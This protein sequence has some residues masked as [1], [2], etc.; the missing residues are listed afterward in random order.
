MYTY[1]PKL[2]RLHPLVRPQRATDEIRDRPERRFRRLALRRMARAGQQHDL[3]RAVAFL[4][5]DLD[6]L[7]R[8]VLV[9]LALHDEHRH[10]DIGKELRDVPLAKPRIEPGVVPAAERVVDVVMPASE[11]RAQ[12]AGF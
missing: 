8:A 1:A 7:H 10:A 5:R 6:L 12:I 2:S 4:L 9:V 11:P 3:D